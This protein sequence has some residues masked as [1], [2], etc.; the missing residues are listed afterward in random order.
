[1]RHDVE[2]LHCNAALRFGSST[3]VIE[4]LTMPC[5]VTRDCAV[6]APSRSDYD[7]DGSPL[8]FYRASFAHRIPR[9]RRHIW[10]L[11]VSGRD[12]PEQAVGSK[13]PAA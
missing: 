1:M 8:K 4:G 10:G 5:L 2:S 13:V 3:Q 12:P 11:E 6:T 7:G 9:F